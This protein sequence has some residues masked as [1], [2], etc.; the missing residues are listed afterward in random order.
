MLGPFVFGLMKRKTKLGLSRN[1]VKE[2][3]CIFRR[4]EASA[5]YTAED[6]GNRQLYSNLVHLLNL[7]KY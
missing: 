6:A 5:H 1:G 7:S 4:M 3:V 2:K